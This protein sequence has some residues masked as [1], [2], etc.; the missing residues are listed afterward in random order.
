MQVIM[1]NDGMDETPSRVLALPHA[2]SADSV[3]PRTGNLDS[4]WEGNDGC[5][6]NF[7]LD[8]LHLFTNHESKKLFKS[9]TFRTTCA[10][11]I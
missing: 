6:N 3:V 9:E 8:E 2:S 7:I 4:A 10:V 5:F 11:C 1:L